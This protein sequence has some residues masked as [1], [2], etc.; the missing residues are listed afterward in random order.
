MMRSIPTFSPSFPKEDGQKPTAKPKKQANIRKFNHDFKL[1]ASHRDD[2]CFKSKQIW[3][4][5]LPTDPDQ[6]QQILQHIAQSMSLPITKESV[7]SVAEQFRILNSKSTHGNNP[8]PMIGSTS[9]S[10]ATVVNLSSMVTFSAAPTKTQH[11]T[12]TELV[13]CY[14]ATNHKDNTTTIV[15]VPWL[16]APIEDLLPSFW[17]QCRSSEILTL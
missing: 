4:Q 3:I 10:Y 6:V 13:F 2:R 12:V 15:V 8:P 9:N 16:I 7:S 5:G 17:P 1:L 11:F 14:T